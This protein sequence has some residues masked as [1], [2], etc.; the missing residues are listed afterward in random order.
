MLLQAREL[1][2]DTQGE[3]IEKEREIK[4]LKRKLRRLR[5]TLGM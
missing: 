5:E 4:D 2:Q 1:I 3:V